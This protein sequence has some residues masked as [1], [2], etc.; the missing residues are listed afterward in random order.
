[1][2]NEEKKWQSELLQFRKTAVFKH[3]AERRHEKMRTRMA[4]L[5]DAALASEDQRVLR[6]A[7]SLREEALFWD[8]FI[9]LADAEEGVKDQT[10]G[11]IVEKM[12]RDYEDPLQAETQVALTPTGG[13]V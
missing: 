12:F 1:L 9:V 6:I 7:Q 8:E 2:T 5:I 13:S 10:S 11:R 4:S 3:L